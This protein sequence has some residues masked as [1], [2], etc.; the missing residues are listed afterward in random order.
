MINM[1]NLLIIDLGSVPQS[2]TFSNSL[3]TYFVINYIGDLGGVGDC[4][5]LILSFPGPS[6]NI[7]TTI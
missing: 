4:G 1:I 3:W 7:R 2:A 5:G 6:L